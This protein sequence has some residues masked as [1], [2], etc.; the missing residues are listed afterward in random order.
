MKR[1][2]FFTTLLVGNLLLVGVILLVGFLGTLREIDHGTAHLSEQFQSQLLAMVR[3]DLEEAWPHAET[4]IAQY[5]HSYS[6][7]PE[8]RLTVIDRE[9]RVLGDSEY[10]AEKMEAHNTQ[11]RPEVMEA[12]AGR[13]GRA[14]RFSET[15]NMTYRYFAEPVTSGGEVAAAVRVAFPVSDLVEN[16]RRIVSGVLYGFASMLFV[17][18]A[19]S[20]L[21]SW[22]W[23]RP[24]RQI[25]RIARNISQ[26]NLGD[27][28][29]VSGPLEMTELATSIDRMRKT[30]A[31]QLATI[32]RQQ[33]RFRVILHHLP[34]AVF[35]LNRA[36]EVLYFN[37]SAKKLFRLAA[38]DRPRHLQQMIR[39][40]NILDFYFRES[41]RLRTTPASATVERLEVELQGRKHAFD[42]DLLE[43]PGGSGAD[44]IT[45]LLVISDVTD[46]VRTSQMK[47]DFVAN[48][49]HEL[50]TPLATI[51]AALDNIGDGVYEDVESLRSVFPVINRHVGRLEALIDDLLSLHSVED[52]S[53]SPRSER[54]TADEQRTWLG[55]L[56]REK[57]AEKGVALSVESDGSLSPFMAD[58][59]RL[60]LILQ[61]LVDNAIKFTPDG[62]RVDVRFAAENGATLVITCTDTG[63]GIAPHEQ[64]RVFE[65]FY[66]SNAS[67]TGDSRVRGTGLGLAIVKHAA[68]R[69]NGTVTLTSHPGRGTSMTVRIP[70][71]FCMEN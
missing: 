61:N 60:G 47:V 57:A 18:A 54:T 25:N 14:V 35:A 42:L 37:E 58:N 19:L 17:A 29:P 10:P 3:H 33:E 51:R 48:A 21:L 45:I 16:R 63:C 67:K 40:A 31:S 28:P 5:C 62:G 38:P 52:K 53:T 4:R 64:E 32:T 22:I 68:E 39:H 69:L 7:R 23:H 11:D 46:L 56:F 70:V 66:Q 41:E 55:E 13:H 27:I 24:L 6:L 59:K 20:V 1:R 71:E 9:G 65:R 34:D 36:D 43:V 8:F 12:L 49:S 2:S 15:K 44:E 30:V 50:R 26:G